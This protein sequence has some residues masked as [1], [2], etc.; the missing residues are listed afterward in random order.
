MFRD[1]AGVVAGYLVM[2]ALVFASFSIAFI[3]M[4]ADRAFEPGTYQVTGLW[5]AVS[6]VLG[7]VAAVMGGTV[8]A[9][10]AKSVRGTTALMVM[11]LALGILMAF[12]VLMADPV[13]KER[14]GDV[15][16]MQAM[17][18]AVQPAWVAL[19]NPVVGAVGVSIGG[20]RRSNSTVTTPG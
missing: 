14:T 12:P 9:M 8:C 13:K 15:G 7:F 4:G 16:N 1:I 18:D 3:A 20:R 19:I 6:F 10:V 17:M 5:I 11:V 2:V